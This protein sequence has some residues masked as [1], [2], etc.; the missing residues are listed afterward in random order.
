MT[1]FSRLIGRWVALAV[2]LV[3]GGAGAVARAQ[4][5]EEEEPVRNIEAQAVR[6]VRM[7]EANF[8]QWVFGNMG[9][10]NAGMVRNKLETRLE[11][12]VDDV[13]R[14]CGL[15]PVQKKKLLVAG[16]GDIK[17]LFDRIEEMRKKF[18]K[19]KNQQNAL[20]MIWQEVQP[21]QNAVNSGLSGEGSIF[22]KALR[23][24][25]TPEQVARHEQADR[26]RLLF[27]YWAKVDL[28]LE[29]LN[30]A[31]GFTTEQ[32]DRLRK[33][34]TEETRP[35]RRLGQNDYYAVLYQIALIPEAKVKP[36]FDEVQWRTLNRQL[37]QARGL[38]IWLKQ[39]GFVPDEVSKE[40]RPNGALR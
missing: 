14:S 2:V 20:G 33:L 29:L 3:I 35:P 30:H 15:T 12:Q 36:V 28:V 39:N 18:D 5:E 32:R 34:L 31:V 17:R 10:G 16:Y 8:E 7:N 19:I 9:G 27:L 4:D 23:T 38:G 24:T 37:A 13:E 22:A 21:L 6:I 25:L 40:M 11:L 1:W 26:D